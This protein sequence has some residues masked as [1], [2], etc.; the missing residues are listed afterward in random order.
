MYRFVKPP[1]QQE[2]RE[3]FYHPPSNSFML[4]LYSDT[5]PPPL[6]RGNYWFVLHHNSSVFLRI[7]Y[8]QITQWVTF[9]YWLLSLSIMPLRFIQFVVATVCFFLLPRV[10]H[11]IDV[12]WFVFLLSSWRTLELS[13][14]FVI[15]NGDAISIHVHVFMW[16]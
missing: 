9:W 2:G 1:P 5:L 3:Q 12:L 14:I 7:S 11:R 10:L 8:H 4:L 16:M 6:T 15:I 13:P